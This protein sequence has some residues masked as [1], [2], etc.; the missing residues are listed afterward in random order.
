MKRVL[1]LT[2]LVTSATPVAA[3]AATRSTVEMA[4]EQARAPAA[5][6]EREQVTDSLGTRFVRY[7]QEVR[8]LPVLDSSLVV[9][10]APG[11][12]GDLVI[13][14]SRRL[15]AASEATVSQSVAIDVARDRLS[16][17]PLRAPA[18]AWL[19]ILP[20][21]RE[22]RTVWQVLLPTLD[23]VASFEVLVDA[24]NRRVLRVRDLLQ[25]ANYTATGRAFLFDPNP[26]VRQGSTSGL[27]D[28]NDSN[29]GVPFG[30]Y[31]DRPL[32][33]LDADVAAGCLTGRWAHVT[34]G[35]FSSSPG[36]VCKADRDWRVPGAGVRRADDRFE[37][38]MAYFHIDRTQ[39]YIQSLGFPNVLNRPIEAT[40][41]E[42]V[43][44]NQDNSFFDPATG[45]VAFGTGFADDGED[46]E[47]IVH[48]Y[49]HAIQDD[50]VPGFGATG[51]ARAIGEGFGDY[52]ASAMSS[53]FFPAQQARFVPCF[54]EW[55][56]FATDGPLAGDPPC[57]RR[58]DRPDTLAERRAACPPDPFF[59]GE[60]AIHCMGE[61]WSSALWTIRGVLGGPAADRLVIQSHFS[62]TP[63]VSFAE[64][65]Q[66]LLA[67]DAA[68]YGRAN[69]ALL[70]SVLAGRG[71]LDP[72]HFDDTP[73]DAA[74]LAV[75]GSVSG[76]LS[77]GDDKHDVYRVE[78]ARGRPIVVRLRSQAAEY[79]LR[80]LPPGASSVDVAPVAHAETPGAN[81]D[82]RYTPA[83]DGS[84]FI[85][86]R[87]IAGAGPY[88]LEIA[89]DD[90]DAD[91]IADG[92]DRCPTIPDPLQTDWDSDGRGDACDRS[93]RI[94][95]TSLRRRGKRVR[96]TG[97]M[98]PVIL[99]VRA[100]SLEVSRRSCRG[101]GCR[102][103]PVRAFRAR[104]GSQGRVRLTVRLRR[105]RYRMRAVVRAR[106]Y[107]PA[108]SRARVF[109]VGG[110]RRAA[111][112]LHLPGA[113][114]AGQARG[115]AA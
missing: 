111:P 7:R 46:D 83:V 92:Q 34:L 68:L 74:T 69:R 12:R 30:L 79:D 97:R 98:L 102:W 32:P 114:T 49:G 57:V 26:V 24:R 11:R 44:G 95:I 112:A 4:I 78:L 51:E 29:A 40:A 56:A 66:A 99:P 47:T 90:Q 52:I 42:D 115:R 64:A 93:S 108:R 18:R 72:E 55:D 37:A 6:L 20:V 60:D 35:S 3:E 58:L 100:F 81:E 19:V 38:L 17:A 21:E 27:S 31:V 59:P 43:G 75:P 67:A 94:R 48:E 86:V 87:A 22:A 25:R 13:D 2:L 54:D 109:K 110:S 82:L 33:R 80:L 91:G 103:R 50:Q 101:R 61:V 84:Y 63:A 53:T 85:D 39:A 77:A 62:L 96:V 36:E 28:S 15:G 71:F 73:G 41:N 105:G 1:V 65:S 104:D 16:G 45:R 107:T 106:G 23:P 89:S 113:T 8:G 14:R 5:Q 70:Q 88:T 9:T 76:T 10:D